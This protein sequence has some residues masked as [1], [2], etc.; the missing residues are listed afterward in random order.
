MHNHQGDLAGQLTGVFLSI[1]W[2]PISFAT[3]AAVLGI[4]TSLLVM[5]VA[6]RETIRTSVFPESR[7]ISPDRKA[8]L[9]KLARLPEAE[10]GYT[11]VDH[12]EKIVEE[13]GGSGKGNE[14]EQDQMDP[15]HSA[16]DVD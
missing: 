12:Q 7:I 10:D 16:Q 5:A 1:A 6:Y 13:D 4:P 9:Q 14:D 11:Q 15:P 8:F 2:L 3:R